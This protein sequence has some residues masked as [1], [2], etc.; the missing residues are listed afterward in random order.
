MSRGMTEHATNLAAA[1]GAWGHSAACACVLRQ[2]VSRATHRND[3]SMQTDDSRVAPPEP[4]AASSAVSLP[5]PGAGSSA[6]CP[7]HP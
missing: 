5:S 3:L 6:G 7:Q 1:I 4:H 2:H